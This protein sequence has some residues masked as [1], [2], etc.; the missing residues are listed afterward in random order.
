ME[1][2]QKSMNSHMYSEE[3]IIPLSYSFNITGEEQYL[4]N[5]DKASYIPHFR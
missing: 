4:I 1:K 2:G 5:T 3:N